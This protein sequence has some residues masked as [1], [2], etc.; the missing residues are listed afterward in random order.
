MQPPYL[1]R[2]LLTMHRT[3]ENQAHLHVMPKSMAITNSGLG[4]SSDI[5]EDWD[6]HEQQSE[7][8]RK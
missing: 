1:N 8:L 6:I 7:A 2:I 3:T 5:V 4:T